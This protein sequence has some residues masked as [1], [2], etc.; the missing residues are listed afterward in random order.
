METAHHSVLMHVT[1]SALMAV[2]QRQLPLR[3]NVSA[4]CSLEAIC[5]IIVSMFCL[6]CFLILLF[7]F[8]FHTA[9]CNVDAVTCHCVGA[10][11]GL[12]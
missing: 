3:E 4:K 2:R 6:F 7:I 8:C 9:V 1:R 10:V 5:V 11:Y 12:L